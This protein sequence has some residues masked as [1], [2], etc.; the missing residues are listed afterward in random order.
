MVSIPRGVTPAIT[1]CSTCPCGRA[2][3]VAFGGRCPLVDRKRGRDELVCL[4]GEAIGSVWFVKRGTVLL[5]RCGPDGVDRPR[6]V[7]GPGTFVGLE[8]LV[9]NT[10]ADSARTTE[11]AVLC[12]IPHRELDAWF[13]P[14]G[15]PVRMA[16]ELTLLAGVTDPPR[17]TTGSSTKRAARWL[18]VDGGGA[19]VPR[20]VLA[21][22]LGMAPETLS[23]ALARLRDAGAIELTRQHVAV[24]DREQLETQAR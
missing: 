1:S 19:R 8:A 15:T 10:Y 23:R 7:R 11:P 20:H 21:A 22:L 17:G 18:L 4:E 5:T 14:A 9:R 3:G 16:L 2:A 24:L 13:G 12:G 6:G